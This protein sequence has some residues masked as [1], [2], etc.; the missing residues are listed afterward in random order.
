MGS[1]APPTRTGD[2]PGQPVAPPCRSTTP[3]SGRSRTIAPRAVQSEGRHPDHVQLGIDLVEPVPT[4]PELVHDPGC[5]ILEHQVGGG[6]SRSASSCPSALVRSR[7]IPRLL[8]L[9]A[10]PWVPTPTIADRREPWCRRS[11]SGPGRVTDST[12]ITSAPRHASTC[13]AQG[14]AHH[15]VRSTTR[16]PA[17]G[18]ASSPA[19]GSRGRAAHS[20]APSCSPARDRVER[21]WFDVVEAE[22]DARLVEPSGRMIDEH[23]TRRRT[24]R[25]GQPSR[26]RARE[27][28]ECASSPASSSTVAEVRG[29]V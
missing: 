20:T 28:P 10:W 24:A 6:E 29:R 18:R 8:V 1:P 7:V 11:A 23:A 22:R 12:L 3:W 14:P 16:R 9:A 27:P 19:T 25:T 15:A 2:P 21:P 4:E 17:R 13:V 5:E 26:R